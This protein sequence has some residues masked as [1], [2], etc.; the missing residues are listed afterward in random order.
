M[1]HKNLLP[2]K[3]GIPAHGKRKTSIARV[4]VKPEGEGKFEVNGKTSEA[5]FGNHVWH[6]FTIR[7]PL[8]AAKM[9]K[10]DV[11]ADVVGGGTTGQA[12]AICLGIAR[13][14]A[15]MDP[16]LR[17]VMRVEGFLTRDP[18]IVERKKPGQPKARKRFQFSKR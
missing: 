13:A 14:I 1:E 2:N 7:K 18:R 17:R 6:K 9:E 12:D 10:A 8:L 15:K 4:W 16:K 5:F 11:R 3:L